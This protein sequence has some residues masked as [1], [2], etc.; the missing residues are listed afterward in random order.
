MVG[1]MKKEKLFERIFA[2]L[3]LHM[4]LLPPPALR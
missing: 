4:P 1:F 2:D 3:E